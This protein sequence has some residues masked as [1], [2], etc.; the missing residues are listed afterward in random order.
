MGWYAM[1][2]GRREYRPAAP[3]GLKI[4]W[5]SNTAQPRYSQPSRGSRLL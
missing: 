4:H 2:K 1:R 5:I 3:A